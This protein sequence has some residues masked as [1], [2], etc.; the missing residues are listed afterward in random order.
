MRLT[1]KLSNGIDRCVYKID[2]CIL[3]LY[4]WAFYAF[5]ELHVCYLETNVNIRDWNITESIICFLH[6][7][8]PPLEIDTGTIMRHIAS[9]AARSRVFASDQPSLN[10]NNCYAFVAS[11]F[12]CNVSSIW[13]TGSLVPLR[14]GPFDTI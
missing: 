10:P 9:P 1:S 13:S 6:S 4:S 11:T 7:G 12:C 3:P 2:K 5:I 14:N 8:K